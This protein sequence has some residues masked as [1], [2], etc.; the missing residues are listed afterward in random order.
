M[1][2]LIIILLLLCGGG[3]GWYVQNQW[4]P[5]GLVGTLLFVV[6]IVILLGAFGHGRVW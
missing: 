6:L 3:G 2:L 5:S 4:G 1:L